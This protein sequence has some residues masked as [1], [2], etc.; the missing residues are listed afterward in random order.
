MW[1][2]SNLVVWRNDIRQSDRLVSAS[3]ARRSNVD[4]VF[5]V[6]S[7]VPSIPQ[8]VRVDGEVLRWNLT[9]YLGCIHRRW[10]HRIWTVASIIWD[11]WRQVVRKIQTIATVV[12]QLVGRHPAVVHVPMLRCDERYAR[13]TWDRRQTVAWVGES[14]SDV[15]GW[16]RPSDCRRYEAPK[17]WVGSRSLTVLGFRSEC[18]LAQ[19]SAR[20]TRGAIPLLVEVTWKTPSSDWLVQLVSDFGEFRRPSSKFNSTTLS[21]VLA[22]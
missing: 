1:A 16:Q 8:T 5:V 19:Q 12:H 3:G 17:L 20:Q 6:I 21:I 15:A 13:G 11:A 2:F 14:H 10:L 9:V 7:A 4:P 22:C 18:Q